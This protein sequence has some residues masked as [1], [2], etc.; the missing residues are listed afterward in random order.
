VSTSSYTL[1][2]TSLLSEILEIC[3]EQGMQ[4]PFIL[5][6]ASPNG[7]VLCIRVSKDKDPAVLAEHFE[8]EGFTFPIIVMVIDQTGEAVRIDIPR[9]GDTPQLH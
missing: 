6:A 3:D 4:P 2:I 1:G 8:P 9:P 7:S 5:C